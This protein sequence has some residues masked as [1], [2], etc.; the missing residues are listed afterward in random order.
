ML[1]AKLM[2]WMRAICLGKRYE[3]RTNSLVRSMSFFESHPSESTITLTW[4]VGAVISKM[5]KNRATRNCFV[6]VG[7]TIAL[8]FRLPI[9]T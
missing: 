5:F 8:G 7:A 1:I 2:T 4:T 9:N 6:Y 3:R